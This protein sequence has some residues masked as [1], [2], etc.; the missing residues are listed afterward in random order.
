MN[1]IGTTGVPDWEV[2]RPW[3]IRCPPVAATI[4]QAAEP[5]KE[6]A[7]GNARRESIGQLPQR[8]LSF[9]RVE[10]CRQARTDQPAVKHQAAPPHLED[11]R[12]RLAGEA[13]L[14]IR[15]HAKR[16]SPDDRANDEPRAQILDLLWR[17]AITDAP[18]A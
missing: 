1:A 10:N 7:Q 4:H 8:Q 16:A 15:N 9:Q 14:P 11:L 18:A 2:N 6:V 5:P 12:P 17:D 3:Q 13:F